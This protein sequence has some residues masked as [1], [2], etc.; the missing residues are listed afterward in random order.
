[1]TKSLSVVKPQPSSALEELVGEYL[2]SLR[3]RGLSPHT[4]S[5]IA[6][7]LERQ[8]LPWCVGADI[9]S[10]DQLTTRLIEDWT[11]YLLEDRRNVHTGKPL[12]RDTV[13]TYVRNLAGFIGWAQDE[14]VIG[15]K[16]KAKQP[17]AEHPLM[18]TLT[19]DEIGAMEDAADSERDKL[20]IRTFADTGIRLGE[21]L[22]LR[23]DDLVEQ[24]RARYLKVRGK[25][26]RER[27]VPVAPALFQ[28]LKRYA[29][30]GRRGATTERVFITVRKSQNSGEYAPLAKRSLQNAIK[31]AAQAAGIER[32]V[33]PHLFRHSY[34]TWAL[35]KGMNPLQL[36]RILGHANLAMIS[37]TYSHLTAS[38]S[39]DAMLALLKADEDA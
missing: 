24:G 34:A 16:V 8:F 39:Y 26:S 10:P 12:A 19:R 6:S 35:R 13:R 22:G 36:Q 5:L 2:T 17:K 21:L 29:D 27:L 30:K 33:H 9:R 3:S 32:S 23:K 28:R 14:G 7:V 1:M 18:E 37:G 38:D 15:A 25:G 4:L 31:F 20:I 11:S